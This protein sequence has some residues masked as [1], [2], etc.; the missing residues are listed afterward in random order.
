MELFRN[1][2]L[3]IGNSILLRKV[4]RIRR[5]ISYSG[6]DKVKTIGLV[7]DASA[8]VDFPSISRFY[9]KMHDR[10]TDVRVIAYYPEK[11][12]PDRYTAIRFLTCIKKD[13]TSFF[14][15]PSSREVDTFIRSSFD[16][17]IDLNFTSELPLSYI[18]TLSLASFKVGLTGSYLGHETFDLMMELKK[19]V[20]VE[21]YLNEII[22]YLEMIKS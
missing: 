15:L 20:Q 11:E 6:F 22:R 3:K 21:N 17:L 14:Y 19:P 7:W 9:Q 8:T 5:K 16:V 4:A 1:T 13:E 2:R 12:L 18:T 10:G